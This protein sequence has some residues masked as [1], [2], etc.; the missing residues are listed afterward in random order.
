MNVKYSTSLDKARCKE[1]LARLPKNRLLLSSVEESVS[2]LFFQERK[3]RQ[4]LKIGTQCV[5][6]S[7]PI[8]AR[9]TGKEI[10][11]TQKK[12]VISVQK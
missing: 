11:R 1:L 12:L 4:Y 9:R 6:V 7:T 3:Q 5:H 10:E 8:F 2:V